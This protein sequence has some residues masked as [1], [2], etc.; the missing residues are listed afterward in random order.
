M[1]FIYCI[2]LK[3][4]LHVDNNKFSDKFIND[5][6]FITFHVFYFTSSI[7]VAGYC[8]VCSCFIYFDCIM[9]YYVS[10]A[11]SAY[12][13]AFHLTRCTLKL[14]AVYPNST[15]PTL[16]IEVVQFPVIPLSIPQVFSYLF[17]I[18]P[19]LKLCL[20]DAIYNYKWV[21]IIHIW[22]N[23]GQRFWDLVDWCHVLCLTCLKAGI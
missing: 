4:V 2:L 16:I 15:R 3:F 23:G 10:V 14:V 5:W 12:P 13:H 1:F 19:H 22:Q 7:M 11:V 17:V 21:K 6:R 18:L 8:R 20:A 9:F